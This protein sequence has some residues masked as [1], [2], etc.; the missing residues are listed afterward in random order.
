MQTSHDHRYP[1]SGGFLL[2]ACIWECGHIS[3]KRALDSV[4]SGSFALK[5]SNKQIFAFFFLYTSFG[6]VL[7]D[8][9]ERDFGNAVGDTTST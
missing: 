2:Y 6:V 8:L 5:S 7:S 9:R 1:L 3:M 4:A